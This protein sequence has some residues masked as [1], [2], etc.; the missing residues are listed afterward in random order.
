MSRFKTNIAVFGSGFVG[1]ALQT[2]KEN[3][4]VV[5]FSKDKHKYHEPDKLLE[6]LKDTLWKPDVVINACGYTGKPNVDGCE[7]DKTNCWNLNVNLPVTM[8]AMCKTLNIPYIHISSGCIY[9][10]YDK[11]YTETDEPNFG[12]G[13]D[14]SS[15]YSK[16]KHA[17][18]I[19]LKNTDSY[20]M[21]IRMP[22][23]DQNHERNFLNKVLKYDNLI[24]FQNSMTRIEDFVEFIGK[25]VTKIQNERN[26]LPW[27]RSVKPG[28]YNVCNPGSVSIQQCVKLFKDN[29]ISN[30]NWKFVDIKTLD[31]KA[32]RSN[33][34]LN[35]DKIQKLGI[36]LPHVNESLSKSVFNLCKS[37]LYKTGL[38]SLHGGLEWQIR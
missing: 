1:T 19:A 13:S 38:Q 24:D 28:L 25:F 37:L 16:T 20:I 33:C 31:L 9:T 35:C 32:N 4:D 26:T 12:L 36:G 18:E 11:E 23:C 2:L 30:A 17:A 6:I 14:T 29:G 10:G 5:V 22:F 21:R 34:V 27:N 7:D 3:H 8:A 15:W